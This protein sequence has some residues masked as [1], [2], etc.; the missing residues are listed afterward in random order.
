LRAGFTVI[1]PFSLIMPLFW[2]CLGW[3]SI[4]LRGDLGSQMISKGVP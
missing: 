4:G 2:P 3:K 1:Y